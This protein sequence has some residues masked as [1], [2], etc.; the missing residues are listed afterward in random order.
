MLRLDKNALQNKSYVWW[1]L[2]QTSQTNWN[3]AI[4]NVNVVIDELP[5][6]ITV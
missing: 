1:N 2:S 4:N 5:S 6:N 3:V